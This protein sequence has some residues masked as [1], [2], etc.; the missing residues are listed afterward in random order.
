MNHSQKP[1][2]STKL[3]AFITGYSPVL[4]SQIT[5]E[6]SLKSRFPAISKVHLPNK[7]GEWKGYA[8][9]DFE[10]RHLFLEFVKMKRIRLPEFSMNLIIKPHKEGKVLK[11]Y[12]KNLEKRKVKVTGIPPNWNDFDLELCFINKSKIENAYVIKNLSSP[13]DNLEGILVFSTKKLAREWC[14]KETLELDFGVK[15]KMNY[16]SKSPTNNNGNNIDC[17]STKNNSGEAGNNQEGKETVIKRNILNLRKRLE[18]LNR[19]KNHFPHYVKPTQ[20]SYF[21]YKE[22]LEKS[23]NFKELRWNY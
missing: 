10:D 7:L 18:N 2:G 16:A 1:Q 15:L 14:N 9:V 5:L 20:K 4:V 6:K 19:V 23:S 22:R 17:S 11:K 8:F 13:Q 12:Q 21:L 3:R